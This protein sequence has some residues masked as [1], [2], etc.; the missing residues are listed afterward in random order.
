MAWI[1]TILPE[2]ATP[3]LQQVYNRITS[4]RGKLSN[5]MA[6]QS[7]DPAAMAA[8]LDL[9]VALMFSHSGL[10]RAEREMIATVV[11]SENRCDYCVQHHGAALNAYWKDQA[12]VDRLIA[13]H[14]TAGL[15][16]R[17]L[18]LADYALTLTGAPSKV[19]ES[20]ITALH[21]HGLNDSDILKLNMITAYFNFVNRIA[22]GLGVE[23][24]AEEVA[25]YRY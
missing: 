23:L 6:V 13:D 12:R 17:E 19:D 5:I 9:Y 7:L 2:Q 15:T 22:A 14:R 1:Q 25:G 4:S 8:H 18:A 10:S 16:A 20:S 11:S 21:T 24:S 3:E